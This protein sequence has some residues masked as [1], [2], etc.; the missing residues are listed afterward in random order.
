MRG[1]QPV[2]DLSEEPSESSPPPV[3]VPE[4]G[5]KLEGVALN[6]A[7]VGGCADWSQPLR[8]AVGD[9]VVG[10]ATLGIVPD[11]GRQADGVGVLGERPLGRPERRNEFGPAS[12]EV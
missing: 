9:L 5:L 7:L 4:V 1:A 11:R 8:R 12:A 2:P 6:S 3:L 10:A